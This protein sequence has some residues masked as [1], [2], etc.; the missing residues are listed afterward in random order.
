MLPM[1]ARES[2]ITPGRSPTHWP[3]G[4]FATQ[5]VQVISFSTLLREQARL[6]WL[7]TAWVVLPWAVIG[8]LRCWPW[9]NVGAVRLRRCLMRDEVQSDFER[10]AR[11]LRDIVFPTLQATCPDFQGMEVE[12][13]LHHRDRL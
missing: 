10:S 13:L 5:R 3:S 4:S 1:V 7:H 6:C 2:A 8:R 9:P 12:V 11:V